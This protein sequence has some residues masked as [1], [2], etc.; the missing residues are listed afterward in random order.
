MTNDFFD[1]KERSSL[2]TR[3]A[4]LR[5]DARAQWGKM[6]A[7]QMSAHCQVPIEVALGE[8]PLKR[9]LIGILFG[10]MAKKKLLDPKPWDRGMPTH[11]LFVVK[12]RREFERERARLVEFV[13]RL[14][15]GGPSK[16]SPHPHPFFGPLTTEEWSALMWKHLDHHLRQFGA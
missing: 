3:I 15:E 6:D 2:L 1:S 9:G 4:A 5:A 10:R 13:R 8:K 16:L 7:A 14:S 11:P 12:D